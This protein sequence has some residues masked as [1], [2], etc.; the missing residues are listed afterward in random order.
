MK[1][2]KIYTDGAC[3]G[4]PGLGGYGV[5]L[6]FGKNKRELSKGFRRTTNNRM[7]IMAAIEGLS[8]LK[9]PCKVTLFSDSQNLVDAMNHGWVLKWKASAW[10]RKKNQDLWER[11]LLLCKEHEVEFTWVKGH[12]SDLYNNRCDELATASIKNTEL[13]DDTGYEEILLHR[14]AQPNML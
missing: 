14:N 6:I 13:S 3:S 9:E 8:A 5:I 7:E 12:D 1:E 4:N 10:K 11:L 2:V